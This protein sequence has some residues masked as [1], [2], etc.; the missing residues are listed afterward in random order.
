MDESLKKRMREN[1]NMN[2]HYKNLVNKYN[3]VLFFVEGY[4]NWKV[5]LIVKDL[6]LKKHDSVV[7]LGGGIG[8]FAQLVHE[9]AQLQQDILCVD[10]CAEMLGKAKK[11]PGVS[12][13]CADAL[14]FAQREDVAY[15]KIFIKEAVHHFRDRVNIFKG[16][17][18]QLAPE[19]R[20]LIITRPSQPEFPFFEAALKAFGRSQPDYNIFK[21]ELESAG[22][23]VN[24]QLRPY[25]LTLEKVRWF[26]MLRQRFMSN[27]A[28][29]S[30]EQIEQGIE[31]LEEK[32]KDKETLDFTD[33]LVF[34]SGTKSLKNSRLPHSITAD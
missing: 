1:E 2:R 25:P 29:F 12:I 32:Y 18:G 31:E 24:V 17:Y 7:D 28:N 26:K 8:I 23:R 11:L 14:S 21:K 5:E 13:L 34:I 10:M 30:D 9:K 33:I 3:H 15:D 20:L 19:G 27:L 4:R 22:F 16:I 6:D